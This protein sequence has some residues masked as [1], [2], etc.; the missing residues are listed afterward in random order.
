MVEIKTYMVHYLFTSGLKQR[1]VRKVTNHVP[2]GLSHSVTEIPNNQVSF[3]KYQIPMPENE[4]KVTA[5]FHQL[6]P[7]CKY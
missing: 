4:D 7:V 1:P 6:L 2:S 3:Y 5:G